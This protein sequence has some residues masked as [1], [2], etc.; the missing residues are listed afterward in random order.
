MANNKRRERVFRELERMPGLSD[1]DLW[2]QALNILPQLPKFNSP[3]DLDMFLAVNLI[4]DPRTILVPILIDDIGGQ[5][6]LPELDPRLASLGFDHRKW[7]NEVVKLFEDGVL[8][9]HS[10]NPCNGMEPC[11]TMAM[12]TCCMPETCRILACNLPDAA[13]Q[14]HN[15]WVASTLTFCMDKSL[16]LMQGITSKSFLRRLSS[17]FPPGGSVSLLTFESL[18]QPPMR[19]LL[20]RTPKG[21][22]PVFTQPVEPRPGFYLWSKYHRY[23][24]VALTYDNLP[25]PL[26][27]KFWHE[28]WICHE[29]GVDF[30]APPAPEEMD[31]DAVLPTASIADESTQK[32]TTMKQT[33][34]YAD[35]DEDGS[36]KCA[37]SYCTCL[38]CA[39]LLLLCSC[40]DCFDCIGEQ[41]F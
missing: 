22:D 18:H 23:F 10:C 32:K 16:S 24:I 38:F 21:T 19:A 30:V 35:G 31:R 14:I 11:M 28:W 34:G 12:C 15:P 25:K 37:S 3:L 41:D 6:A 4:L 2:R 40:F 5:V 1:R 27:P 33:R 17:K 20:R 39:N 26:Q 9:F 29:T 8:Q 36:N 13:G 7:D